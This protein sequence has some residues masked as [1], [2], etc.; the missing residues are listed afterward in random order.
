[1]TTSLKLDTTNEALAPADSM[2]TMV[3]I[4]S[5][6]GWLSWIPFQESSFSPGLASAGWTAG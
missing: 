5:T 6:T 1:M 2:W 4:P 3:A